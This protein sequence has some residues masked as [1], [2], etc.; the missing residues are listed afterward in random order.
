MCYRQVERQRDD[1][2]QR[3]ASTFKA[4][5]ANPQVAAPLAH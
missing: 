5:A 2:K 1:L 3:M 4:F